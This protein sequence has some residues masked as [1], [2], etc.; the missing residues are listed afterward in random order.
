MVV[1][2]PSLSCEV[3]VGLGYALIY[4]FHISTLHFSTV[5]RKLVLNCLEK[6]LVVWR[7]QFVKAL[8]DVGCLE[9][10]ISS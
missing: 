4:F 1:M 3:S 2:S 5:I 7:I 10:E 9:A 6:V 8:E